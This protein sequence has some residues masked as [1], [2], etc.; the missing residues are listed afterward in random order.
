[1]EA[2]PGGT[3]SKH[4]D[5]A[6]RVILAIT[7]WHELIGSV[8]PQLKPLESAYSA[9]SFTVENAEI[10]IQELCH[11]FHPCLL[12]GATSFWCLHYAK[13]CHSLINASFCSLSNHTTVITCLA[14]LKPLFQNFLPP[15]LTGQN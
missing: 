3:V 1:M 9:V 5:K 11:Q 2:G 12:I 10:N 14:S 4:K 6:L 7:T 8:T 13:L 15:Y